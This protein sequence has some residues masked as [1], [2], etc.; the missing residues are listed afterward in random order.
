M[1]SDP[2][3]PIPDLETLL[4]VQQVAAIL[5]LKPSTI[6]AYAERG[7]LPCV[8]IGGRLRFRPSDVAEWIEQRLSKGGT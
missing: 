2:C 6:R 1:A 7:D 3:P 8:R 4:T 5:Q